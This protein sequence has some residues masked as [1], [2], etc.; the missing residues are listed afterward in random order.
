MLSIM[1]CAEAM[2]LHRSPYRAVLRYSMSIEPLAQYFL[3]LRGLTMS[4]S[5]TSGDPAAGSAPVPGGVFCFFRAA[6]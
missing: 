5:L 1:I 3:A 2:D 4:N 6:S